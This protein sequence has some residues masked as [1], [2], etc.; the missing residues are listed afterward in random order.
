MSVCADCGAETDEFTVIKHGRRRLQLCDECA[1]IRLENEEIQ[2]E[3]QDAMR[4]MME[5]K[6]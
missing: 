2:S 5:Y 3:A 1:E 6:G 4:A